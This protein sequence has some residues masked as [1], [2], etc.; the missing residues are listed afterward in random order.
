MKPEVTVREIF[1]SVLL[2]YG[3][4][5][6]AEDRSNA[7][8]YQ[9]PEGILA[10][11]ELGKAGLLKPFF[12]N[13]WYGVASER[14]GLSRATVGVALSGGGLTGY[15]D[16]TTS[17]V[18]PIT[19]LQALPDGR[20]YVRYSFSGS[21]GVAEPTKVSGDARVPDFLVQYMTY[22]DVNTMFAAGAFVERAYVDFGDATTA[23]NGYG[24]RL[25]AAEKFSENWGIY[26]RVQYSLGES[27][28]KVDIAPGL[29]SVHI[30]GDDRLYLQGELTGQFRTEDAAVIPEDWVIHPSLGMLYN[31]ANLESTVD[32]F[33]VRSSGVLGPKEKYG[34]AWANLSFEKEVPPGDWSPNLGIGVEH[35]FVN[36][37]DA[38]IDE[39]TYA[40]FS[41]GA[42]MQ[43]KNG[44][45]I[46]VGYSR[47]Q[48]LNGNRW[49]QSFVAALT[50]SF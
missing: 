44:R 39:S 38:Y 47:H 8:G 4:S 46:D 12:S 2:F 45:R 36:S 6:H 43:M 19:A 1:I 23:R 41:A 16:E 26:G 18:L 28:T 22:P 21:V 34:T 31:Q 27:E 37:L 13:E 50:M 32:N 35:E 42:S 20:S 48:G 24:L 5:A 29:R 25:D 15:K 14:N 30:Q 17:F 40:I 11:I 9:L 3:V 49:S 7:G 33:G 10:Q